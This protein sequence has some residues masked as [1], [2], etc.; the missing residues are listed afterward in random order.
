[1]RSFVIISV[2]CLLAVPA[3]AQTVKTGSDLQIEFFIFMS[4]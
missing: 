1:M 2:L 3:S 4:L